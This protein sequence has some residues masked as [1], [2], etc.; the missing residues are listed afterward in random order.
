MNSYL[1]IGG[2]IQPD[3]TRQES[4]GR[5]ILVALVL[6]TIVVVVAAGIV[7]GKTTPTVF[8]GSPAVRQMR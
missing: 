6:I 5:Q 1:L 3:T 8:A 4:K 2:S 7:R